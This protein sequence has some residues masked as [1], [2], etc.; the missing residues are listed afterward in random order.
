MRSN[1]EK[2]EEEEA[3]RGRE[4]EEEGERGGRKGR[5]ERRR[6]RRK[7][8][9]GGREE[10]NKRRF[11]WAFLDL[12]FFLSSKDERNYYLKISNHCNTL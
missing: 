10:T 5:R 6:E 8:R 12:S 9:G 11:G 4:E 3:K 2:E 1:W 7:G